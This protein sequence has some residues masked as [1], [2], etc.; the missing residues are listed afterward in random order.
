MVDDHTPNSP[1][2][3]AVMVSNLGD[4]VTVDDVTNYLYRQC[5]LPEADSIAVYGVGRFASLFYD[6][7]ETGT[8]FLGYEKLIRVT[9][10]LHV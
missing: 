4:G 8:L 10:F 2:G 5:E 9:Y 1:F 6:N 7:H 3:W